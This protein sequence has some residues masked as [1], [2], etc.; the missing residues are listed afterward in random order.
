MLRVAAY[1]RSSQVF[2]ALCAVAMLA[3]TCLVTGSPFKWLSACIIFF[4]TFFIY[5]ASRLSLAVLRKSANAGYSI[6]IE[7][8]SVSI[9]SCFGALLALFCLLTACSFMQLLIFMSISLLS[10]IY[11]MPIKLN[12]IRIA[13]L[14]NNLYLKNI[15]LSLTWASATVLFPLSQTEFNSPG[16]EMLFLFLRRFFFIYALTVIYDLRDLESDKKA[17]MQTIALRFGEQ[18]TKLWS[19]TALAFFVLLILIDPALTSARNQTLP[20]A[21]M[22]SAVLAAVITLNTHR[23]RNKSYYSFVVDGAIILQFVLVLLVKTA[24]DMVI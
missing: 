12:R 2:I 11:M 22:A 23:I 18:A 24:G 16:N 14:R 10:L 15:V 1:F 9:T 3:E 4:A 7:G 21:L 20:A 13:G 6:R 5:N 19:L 17:G 8:N